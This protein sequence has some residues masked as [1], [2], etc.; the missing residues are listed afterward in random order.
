MVQLVGTPPE[1]VTVSSF[2]VSVSLWMQLHLYVLLLHLRWFAGECLLCLGLA[3]RL[4]EL[5]LA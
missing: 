1:E 5:G 2:E 3:L 4:D